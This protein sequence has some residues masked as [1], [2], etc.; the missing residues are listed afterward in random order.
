[1]LDAVQRHGL[2]SLDLECRAPDGHKSADAADARLAIPTHVVIGS[3]KNAIVLPAD[4]NAWALLRTMCSRPDLTMYVHYAL[5]DLVLLHD[6]RHLRLDQIASRIIDPMVLQFLVHERHD[7]GLKE[8][9]Q[10]YFRKRMVTYKEAS[11]GPLQAEI[12]RI[13]DEI[14][15]LSEIQ[16]RLPRQHPWPDW[17]GSDLITPVMI[18]GKVKA[19]QD[20]LYPGKLTP[21]G[22]R[23]WSAEERAGR[24]ELAAKGD[25]LIEATFGESAVAATAHA[26]EHDAIVPLRKKVEELEVQKGLEFIEYAR[27]DGLWTARLGNYLERK[28]AKLGLGYWAE[29]ECQTYLEA[30]AM[31]VTGTPIDVPYLR[32]FG[33]KL[34][35]VI[36]SLQATIFDIAK[37][38]FNIDSPTQ[39]R[40]LLFVQMRLMPPVI[41]TDQ[42]GRRLPKLTPA[43]EAALR[44]GDLDVDVNRPETLTDEVRSD[45]LA[46]D[47]E[48][49]ERLEHPIGQAVLDYRT[50]QKLHGTYT[51]AVL[52]RVEAHPENRICS[53]FNSIGAEKTGR[54]S[55]SDPN[56]QNIPSRSKGANYDPRVQ[57]LGPQLRRAYIAPPGYVL[58]VADMSQIELRKI[59]SVVNEPRMMDIYHE[60]MELRGVRHYVGDIHRTTAKNLAIER[61]SAKCLDGSTYVVVQGQGVRRIGDLL[62]SLEPGDHR[63]IDQLRLSDARGGWVTSSQ[64]LRRDR[65]PCVTVVTSRG[66]ITCTKD[67]RWLTTNGLKEAETLRPGD[68]L[69]DA[70]L[71]I[72]A[73]LVGTPRCIRINP[74]TGDVG[75]GPAQLTL[76]ADWAYFAGMYQG[77]GAMVN[78]H[79][80]VIAHDSHDYAESWRQAIR[81]AAGAVGLPATTDRAKRNTRIGSWVVSRYMRALGL[82]SKKGKDIVIPGWVTDG[83]QSVVEAYLAGLFDTDGTVSPKEVAVTTRCPIFAGQISCLLRLLGMDVSILPS[84]NA[85]Y[86][87]HYY[88]IRLRN[89]TV[90]CF[91]VTVGTRMR[92]VDKRTKLTQYADVP[93]ETRRAST[94]VKLIIDAGD[95][96]VY[97]FHVD[98]EDHLYLQG[99]FIGHNNVNFGFAYGMGALRFCRQQQLYLPGTYAYDIDRAM[100]W[101][102]GFLDTYSGLRDFFQEAERCWSLG[103]R[104]VKMTTGRIR[105]F[106]QEDYVFGITGGKILNAIV[107]GSCAD[108][109]KIG[110]HV[111]RNYV[112]PVVPSLT[113]VFQVHDEV[114]YL[115]KIEEAPLAAC[116]IK[117]ALEVK[118]IPIA[119]PLLASVKLCRN[120]A[121]KDDDD[122]PE[123]GTFYARIDDTDQLF[124]PETWGEFRK[125]E[126]AGKVQV[127]S[128]GAVLSLEQLETASRYIPESLPQLACVQNGVDV[129]PE[130]VE[131]TELNLGF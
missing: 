22:N 57:K 28:V 85:P 78:D 20:R 56:L 23:S 113:S 71:P 61:K 107:Q 88:K 74:F 126:K 51:G 116:L 81:D 94:V 6:R 93:R 30:L 122:V 42:H 72:A 111:I 101:R 12:N 67:H 34:Q 115:A 127:K 84:W 83:G 54:W 58:I 41:R 15:R 112:K 7:R 65:R 8:L 120:W 123:F 60:G 18:R 63:P 46:C 110:I 5:Y 98:S 43:A 106:V 26:I 117:R 108:M 17:R 2:F 59:A 75:S 100:K 96:T 32:E 3:L 39:M 109:L 48:T 1:V 66:V 25:A 90:A 40:E 52:T 10:R 70:D 62:G 114:G 89:H 21:A 13:E 31:S 4:D 86:R 77:D 45:M 102:T 19:E 50:A 55:S 27:A 38:T 121:E 105:H 92:H 64:G 91:A 99:G 14:H 129:L 97:D 47:K 9:V 103:M 95:R 33:E 80:M 125:L 119:T 36:S 124:T 29:I 128:A 37:Q 118:Y 35:P 79:T 24:K 131:T 53:I 44:N 82:G 11:N 73:G 68:E 87:K 104:E 16:R 76:N 69:P 49:M 130:C